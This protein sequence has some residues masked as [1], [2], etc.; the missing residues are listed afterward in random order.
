MTEEEGWFLPKYS[1][2]AITVEYLMNVLT[3]SIFRC[4]KAD[5]QNPPYEKR[6][7]S[8]IDLIAYLETRTAPT[9]F[10]ISIARLPDRQ[11]LITLAYSFDPQLEIFTGA[12]P[13]D[14]LVSIPLHILE[15]AKFFDPYFT[16]TKI[17][18]LKKT[19]EQRQ[20]EDFEILQKRRNKKERRADYLSNQVRKLNTELSE[21]DAQI[22]ING[23]N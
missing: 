18:V 11:L 6:I 5:V 20:K 17:P 15:Q 1:S 8:N 19:S 4:R 14:Q 2:R 12:K 23:N 9:P 21:L 22:D 7:W 16:N 10:G 3:G 13:N